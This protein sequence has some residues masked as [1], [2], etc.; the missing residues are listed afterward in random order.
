MRYSLILLCSLVASSASA[1]MTN[2]YDGQG[3]PA[4]SSSNF[5][6]Q[7]NYYDAQDRPAGSSNRFGN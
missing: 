6:N 1:Q 4:G 7:T 3:R 5:G 2:Y